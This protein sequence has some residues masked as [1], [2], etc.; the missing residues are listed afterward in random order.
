MGKIKPLL[1][2]G[3]LGAGELL[4]GCSGG[5]DDSSSPERSGK[6]SSVEVPG[7]FSWEVLDQLGRWALRNGTRIKMGESGTV[8]GLDGQIPAAADEERYFEGPSESGATQELDYGYT[9]DAMH[10]TLQ[11][12]T[13]VE[14]R[15][16]GIAT[17]DVGVVPSEESATYR[18][19]EDANSF[20]TFELCN[21]ADQGQPG[22][23]LTAGVLAMPAPHEIE[24]RVETA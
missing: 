6:D 9:E 16:P 23:E 8:A 18:H 17:V 15:L 24:T 3:A 12:G 7:G 2:V 19:T 20:G 22:V 14:I 11:D 4:A 13:C 10:I 21:P 5:G 1:M